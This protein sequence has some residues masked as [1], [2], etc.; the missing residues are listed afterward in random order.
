MDAAAAAMCLWYAQRPGHVLAPSVAAYPQA[1]LLLPR[2]A[3]RV[4]ASVGLPPCSQL[5]RRVA[6]SL[7]VPSSVTRLV[8]AASSQIVISGLALCP[9]VLASLSG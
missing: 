4:F 7:E 1:R 8:S 3:R 5:H 9:K 2:P 6:A